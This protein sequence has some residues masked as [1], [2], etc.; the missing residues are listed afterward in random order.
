MSRKK[1]K[2]EFSPNAHAS[3]YLIALFYVGYQLFKLIKNAVT[4]DPG[5]PSALYLVL[6]IAVLGG[7]I[8]LLIYLIW[9]MTHLDHPA[10]VSPS[11]TDSDTDSDT[12]SGADGA[13]DAGS[14]NIRAISSDEAEGTTA[15]EQ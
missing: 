3:I 13:A 12:N 10:A 7:G 11:G 4:G 14:D 6:G 9:R 5:A 2:R 8:I 1:P 15:Q